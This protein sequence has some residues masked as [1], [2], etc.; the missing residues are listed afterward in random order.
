[1]S[2]QIEDNRI[3]GHEVE[4]RSRRAPSQMQLSVEVR[5]RTADSDHPA[6]A[7]WTAMLAM[8][9]RSDSLARL[10]V[11]GLVMVIAGTYVGVRVNQ[12]WI[13]VDD[14]I[15]AQS[16]VRV[17]QGQLPHSDFVEIYTGGL[18]FIHAA[19]FRLFGVNLLSLRICVFLFF[20]A[21]VP[22]VY[23]VVLR[24]TPPVAAGMVTLLA[25]AW[26]F[27][28]YE[29]AM[30]SWYNLFFATFGA[31][32]L[33]HYLEVRSR[34]W[35]FI[36]GL[37]GGIS[38]LI[39]VIGFY[40]IA[41]VLLFLAFLEQS[42]NEQQGTGKNSWGYRAFSAGG[43]LAFLGTLISVL[44]GR[45]AAGEFYHFLL[46]SLAV[47]GMILLGE[48][49]AGAGTGERF[50]TLVRLV[51]PFICGVL[52]PVVLFLIPYA[53]AGSVGVFFPGVTSSAISHAR[54]LAEA[55]PV[56]PQY[57][58]AVLPLVAFL[59]A[60]MYWKQFQ[61]R[62]VGAAVALLAVVVVV[63][64]M[65]SEAVYSGVWFSVA[66][67]TPVVVAA[68]A[69]SILALRSQNDIS[70]LQ[71]ERLVLLVALAATCTL[72]QYP[73]PV[74]IY[75]CYALPLT[76]L[77]LVAVVTTV[78]KQ[79]GTYVLAALVGLYL[80]F[81]VVCMI[82]RHLAEYSHPIGR[83]DLLRVARGGLEIEDE[84]FFETVT[85]FLQQRAS[86]G[87]MYAGNDCP[88]L[89]FLT[90]LRNV[91]RDDNGVPA[92]EVLKVLRSNDIKVVVIFESPYF[93]GAQTSPGVRAEVMKGYSHSTLFGPFHVF[94]K[95]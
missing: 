89:Y 73:L 28:N 16:A 74:P 93:P 67:L 53:L 22:A 41:G 18:S 4:D 45:L 39:K 58:V 78:R 19:A 94:W 50:A 83:R 75:L 6:T 40:Y 66:M 47:V 57:L 92:E 70:K 95:E 25:I 91:T 23:Y 61:G 44:H 80:A 43:L 14:G 72:V 9:S 35:L 26:S 15:L 32:A 68:G 90:G 8:F 69:A 48:R 88:E 17:F 51:I 82:P 60:G 77:A 55:R 2:E 31:A 42:E 65:R 34:R 1:V 24:F 81:G 33:L 3:P 10:L 38:V 84:P 11:L 62:V 54:D 37:C 5:V 36:A 30:P 52:V 71:R 21:W 56:P 87:L 63:R 27:P 7:A 29:A 49:K 86:N 12:S 13:A 76:L 59:A 79:R 85:I 46:P 20:L 64:A